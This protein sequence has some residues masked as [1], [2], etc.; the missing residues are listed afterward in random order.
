[1]T[2]YRSYPAS[3]HPCLSISREDIDPTPN[4]PTY[5]TTTTSRLTV[6]ISILN[7]PHFLNI[8]RGWNG[9]ADDRLLDKPFIQT[10]KKGSSEVSEV[11]KLIHHRGSGLFKH[12]IICINEEKEE[13]FSLWSNKR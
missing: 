3:I 9:Y 4:P 5:A 13:K 11:G 7:E 6:S 10:R 1:M 2:H 12:H 8:K